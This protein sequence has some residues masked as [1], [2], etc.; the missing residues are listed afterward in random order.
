M[1]LDNNLNLLANVT[2]NVGYKP[3]FLAVHNLPGS[4]GLLV[5][6]VRCENN[7]SSDDCREHEM[8]LTKLDGKG[9]SSQFA[10]F[11]DEGCAPRNQQQFN[12]YEDNGEICVFYACDMIVEDGKIQKTVK[13]RCF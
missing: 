11:K 10:K 6:T 12:F 13:Y 9:S 1:Q 4:G 3:S 7:T 8:L 5:L 2:R